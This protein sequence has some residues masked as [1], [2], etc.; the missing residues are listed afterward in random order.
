MQNSIKSRRKPRMCRVE[1]VNLDPIRP[2][3]VAAL[4]VLALSCSQRDICALS[5]VQLGV[6]FWRY[7]VPSRRRTL[8]HS[9]RTGQASSS[10]GKTAT[11][12]KI[13]TD[14]LSTRTNGHASFPPTLL[15]QGLPM[16]WWRLPQMVGSSGSLAVCFL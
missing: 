3:K 1:E 10:T 2:S 5:S 16:P 14:T 12:T 8:Q 11:S 9:L 6:S 13:F 4:T 7:A 15:A